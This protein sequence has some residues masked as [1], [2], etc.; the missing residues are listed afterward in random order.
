[1]A[2]RLA[3][4]EYTAFSFTGALQALQVHVVGIRSEEEP[5]QGAHHVVPIGETQPPGV[6]QVYRAARAEGKQARDSA[7]KPRRFGLTHDHI[8]V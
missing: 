8:A 3:Q 5:R 4:T 1:M 2:A 6:V 7:A